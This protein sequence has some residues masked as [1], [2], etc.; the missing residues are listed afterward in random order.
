MSEFFLI[1]NFFY[2]IPSFNDLLSFFLL[3]L[4]SISFFSYGKII[5]NINS[6][7]NFF[8]GWGFFYFIIL[9]FNFFLK[10]N[11]NAIILTF[12]IIGLIYAFQNFNKNFFIIF[13][14]QNK[15]LSFFLIIYLS[16]IISSN[17]KEWD[18]FAFWG[19]NINY[20]IEN[21]FFPLADD[22]LKNIHGNNPQT[23]GSSF[24]IYTASMF[25]NILSEN[26]SAIF[27]FISLFM[28]FLILKKNLFIQIISI[29]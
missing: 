25:N 18:S 17:T 11:L 7:F 2:F 15:V 22:Q 23:F 19:L 12:I 8:I 10:V 14:K 28:F 9:V 27:N 20:L 29:C 4:L 13:I 26:S 16:L 21:G 1:K 5:T 3:L 6:E 24:I